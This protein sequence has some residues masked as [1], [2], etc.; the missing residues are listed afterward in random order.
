MYSS[1]CIIDQE[2]VISHHMVCVFARPDLSQQATINL[3]TETTGVDFSQFL[4]REDLACS[5]KSSLQRTQTAAFLL[6]PHTAGEEQALCHIFIIS[7]LPLLSLISPRHPISKY[8]H[9]GG[10]TPINELPEVW[11][12]PEK[13]EVLWYF[14]LSTSLGKSKDYGSLNINIFVGCFCKKKPN[15]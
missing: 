9:T 15:H 4:R 13:S 14:T 12:S 5:Q 3:D 1:F 6:G 10:M 2:S 7:L 11:F 8:H